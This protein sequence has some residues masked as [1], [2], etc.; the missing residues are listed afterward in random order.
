M[1]PEAARALPRIRPAGCWALRQS[2]RAVSRARR[3]CMITRAEALL[4]SPKSGQDFLFY[5]LHPHLFFPP[6][7][8]CISKQQ[9]CEECGT[10]VE[11][12]EVTVGAHHSQNLPSGGKGKS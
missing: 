2:Q 5:F 4:S 12:A 11:G 3:S 6:R 8:C 9:L 1:R 7:K 10:G